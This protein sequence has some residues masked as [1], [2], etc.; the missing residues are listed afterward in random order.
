ME[1]AAQAAQPLA[2]LV[3]TAKLPNLEV[4]HQ[5]IVLL[6]I[7]NDVHFSISSPLHCPT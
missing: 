2:I 5:F 7:L 4:L 3:D 6:T 1:L